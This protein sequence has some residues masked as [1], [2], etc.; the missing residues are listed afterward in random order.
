MKKLR[1]LDVSNNDIAGLAGISGNTGLSWLAVANNQLETLAD[2][3]RLV[4]LKGENKKEEK[5]KKRE[6][7]TDE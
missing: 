1:R 3:Q 7:I 6:K 5:K 4:N 2:I